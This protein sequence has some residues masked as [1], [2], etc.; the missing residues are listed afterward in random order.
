MTRVDDEDEEDDK[1]RGPGGRNIS[2][3]VSLLIVPG[4]S[5]FLAA[6]PLESPKPI[7]SLSDRLE[8]FVDML[9][10]LGR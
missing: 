3:P 1:V 8:L 7:R 4:F 9:E 10:R 2:A 6:D 5:G